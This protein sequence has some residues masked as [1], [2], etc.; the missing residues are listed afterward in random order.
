MRIRF[1]RLSLSTSVVWFPSVSPAADC[2]K[3][4]TAEKFG[5]VGTRGSSPASRRRVHNKRL[6]KVRERGGFLGR[7]PADLPPVTVALWVFSGHPTMPYFSLA[8]FCGPV[9][10]VQTWSQCSVSK[11]QPRWRSRSPPAARFAAQSLLLPLGSSCS[12]SSSHG[13]L[14]TVWGWVAWQIGLKNCHF[15]VIN[16]YNSCNNASVTGDFGMIYSFSK[17]CPVEKVL[18]WICQSMLHQMGFRVVC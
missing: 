14:V 5:A 16:V 17:L 11:G 9:C 15:P 8:R 3:F 2:L 18:N 6:W 13:S 12:L 10:A 7:R 1:L 4:V